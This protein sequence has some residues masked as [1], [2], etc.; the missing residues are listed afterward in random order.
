MKRESDRTSPAPDAPRRRLTG[1][2]ASGAVLALVPP[3]PARA[4]DADGWKPTK[5]VNYVISVAP[6]GSVDLYARG[7]K[8]VLEQRQ[9]TNGQPVIAENRPG[10]AGLLAIQAVQRNAGDGHW[11]STFHTG[12]IAGMVSGALKADVRELTPV[13][14][15]VEESTFLV[16]HAE[17]DL[18]TAQALVERLKRDPTALRFA[19]APALGQNI[20]L[21][22]A[23]PLKAA[24][25][26]IR[27]LTVAPFRSSGDSMIALVGGHVDVVC[28][29]GPAIVP[30]LASNRVRALVVVSRERAGAPFASVP[31]WRELG[32]AADYVSY[33]GVQLP[34]GA[35]PDQV[36]FWEQTMKRVSETP[37]WQQLVAKSGNKAVF[38]GAADS[39]RYVDEEVRDTQALLGEL[40]LVDSLK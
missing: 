24:G 40:G 1:L 3:A 10:A 12:G 13:A 31:T 30:H 35:T 25:V 16:V 37:D 34:R 2:L 27:K 11:L 5:P 15:M 6:G 7:I 28:A 4:A 26:D 19:V 8:S 22:L 32:V 33:N 9:W 23:K 18:R 36:R 14:M 20:H 17:S 39:R 38:I 21:A 29:T